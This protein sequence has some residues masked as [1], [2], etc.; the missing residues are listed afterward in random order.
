MAQ[1]RT[2]TPFRQV[3]RGLSAGTV[4]HE[5]DHLNGGLIVDRMDD[6]STMTTWDN[7]A[8]HGMQAYLDRIAPIIKRT[9]P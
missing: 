2:G 4:Q 6:R 1:D 3:Y 7:F 8:D 5:V 9:E